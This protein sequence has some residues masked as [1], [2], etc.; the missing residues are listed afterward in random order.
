MDNNPVPDHCRGFE[1]LEREVSLRIANREIRGKIPDAVRGTF[2]RIGPGR[3]ELG[4][5]TF[6][7]WF[8]GDDD[9]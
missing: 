1:N 6:G 7:H 8:D 2:L 9:F 3:S 5:R 4:G